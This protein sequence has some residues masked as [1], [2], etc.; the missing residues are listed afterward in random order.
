MM[1]G[2][3]KK[4]GLVPLLYDEYNYG[5]VLQFYA[6]QTALKK[7]GY[8]IVI[9]KYNNEEKVIPV[10]NDNDTLYK[11]LRMFVYSLLHKNDEKHLNSVLQHRRDKIK[12]FKE[13][14]YSKVEDEKN[15]DISTFCAVICGSDQI[16]N[17][18]WARKRNF[19]EFVP[20]DVNKIIYA[21]SLGTE[22]MLDSE[23]E[24]FKPRIERINHI[25]VREFSA[26]KLLDEFVERKDIEVVADPTLLLTATDWE[27]IIDEKEVPSESYILTYFL[28][29]YSRIKN[30]ISDFA[31]SKRIHIVNI[32]Y[33]SGERVDSEK[34]GDIRLQ[35]LSP[36]EF[37]GLIKNAEYVFTDSFHA[38]VFSTLFQRQFY[39]FERDG[40]KNMSGRIN[41]LMENFHLQSRFIPV[42]PI[43]ELPDID[44]SNNDYWQDKILT[45]S[46]SFIRESLSHE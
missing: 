38:C 22:K 15:I 1:S 8:E 2:E 33:A 35:D 28:G 24:C 23:K 36:Q 46:I 16:W 10:S 29:D 5:G 7:L 32:P 30:Y 26:K 27:L 11:K 37:L 42:A 39:V 25:S 3:N 41:T 13:Q 20:D 9:L 31:G 19:L 4:I 12:L 34:F 21:A 44:Y 18:K 45:K 6:L 43:Q 14:Y 17:P 40:K